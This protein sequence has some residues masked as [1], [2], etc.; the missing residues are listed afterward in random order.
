M[1]PS[2]TASIPYQDDDWCAVMTSKRKEQSCDLSY[3]KLVGAHTVRPS[4][5]S[6]SLPLASG[7]QIQGKDRRVNSARRSDGDT[8]LNAH[9]HTQMHSEEAF[10]W[11]PH[12]PTCKGEKREGERGGVPAGET[13]GKQNQPISKSKTATARI[14]RGDTTQGI[15]QSRTPRGEKEQ[16]DKHNVNCT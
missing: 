10:E 2:T 15:I 6:F 9:T 12:V 5:F 3:L 4:P 8:L 16:A 14:E 7:L 11:S 1:E 13:E